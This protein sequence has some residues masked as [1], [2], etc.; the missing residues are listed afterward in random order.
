MD[1]VRL[2]AKRHTGYTRDEIASKLG[3]T[4]GG[5][6]TK[7]LEALAASDFI[8]SYHPFGFSQKEIRYKLIDSFCLFYLR[9]VDAHHLSDEFF[10]QHH[11]NTPQLNSWRGLAFEQVC[12]SHV[13]KIK[14]AL[15]V[16]GVVS[17]ESAWIIRGD[18]EKKGSQIDMLIVRDDRV[19]NLCEMKFLSKAFDPKAE[20]E[21]TFRERISTLQEHLSFKQ[22]IHLTLVT[23]VG[24]KPNAHS[25]VFQQIVTI[26]QLID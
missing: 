17:M 16:E 7:M 12:F 15:G 10:L 9:F 1:I 23:T 6:F 14:K 11:Q 21:Q 3:M 26:D 5:S 13:S 4:S 24:L 25:G 19:V 8:V 18:E 20:D 2:L 22:T